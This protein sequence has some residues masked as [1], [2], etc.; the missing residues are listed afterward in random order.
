MKRFVGILLVLVL[1]LA[2]MAP[3]AAES[4]VF[5]FLGNISWDTPAGEADRAI[6]LLDFEERY[7]YSVEESKYDYYKGKLFGRNTKWLSMDYQDGKL[8]GIYFFLLKGSQNYKK[9][10]SALTV[11]LGEPVEGFLI[12]S[13]NGHEESHRSLIWEN[14][15]TVAY[16]TGVNGNAPQK[17]QKGKSAFMVSLQHKGY[18]KLA[19]QIP[20]EPKEAPADQAV[21]I[22]SNRLSKES[23]GT[24]LQKLAYKNNTDRTIDCVEIW[25]VSYDING[26]FLAPYGHY[27]FSIS[28]LNVT[29]KPGKASAAVKFAGAGVEGARSVLS[30]VVSYRFKDGETVEIPEEERVWVRYTLK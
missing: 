16:L 21:T 19:Y 17:C 18:E 30:A 28:R 9:T 1:V 29:A 11:I 26:M 24:S 2:C 5:P 23:N 15:D 3:A 20:E 4:T 6:R 22:H 8:N 12:R 25:S 7:N 14:A 10:V 27:R 13:V